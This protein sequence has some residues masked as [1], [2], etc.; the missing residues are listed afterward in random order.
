MMRAIAVQ[1]VRTRQQGG[2][3]H[4]QQSPKLHNRMRIVTRFARQQR[5]TQSR[6]L[7]VNS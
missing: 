6:R 3:G 5:V 2:Y 7:I 4:T 1:V